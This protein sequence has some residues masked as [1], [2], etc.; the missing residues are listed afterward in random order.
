M[1]KIIDLLPDRNEYCL[2]IKS[3]FSTEFCNQIISDKKD[4]FKKAISHYPTSYRNNERQVIDTVEFSESL[5]NEIKNYI[6]DTITTSGISKKEKGTW[7]LAS[8]NSR[9]RICRYLSN[10]YFNK[11][12]DGIHYVDENTQSKLTFM[13]YLNGSKDFSGG[14]TLFFDAKNSSAPFKTYTPEKGDLIIFDHNLWHSGEIVSNGTKYVLRSD[15]IYTKD[16]FISHK[17]KLPFAEGHLGYIWNINKFNNRIITSGRDKK[18][19]IWDE[20]GNKITEINAHKN[21]ILKVISFDEKTFISASRDTSVNIYNETNNNQFKTQ[22]ITNYHKTTVLSLCKA[23]D[24]HFFSVDADGKVNLINIDGRLI[25]TKKAHNEWI[26]D[27]VMLNKSLFI[28][29][30]EDGS[31]KIWTYKAFKVIAEYK[32]NCPINAITI[33]NETIY[34]GTFKGDVLEF[35][36][37]KEKQILIKLNKY[38]IHTDLIRRLKVYNNFLL[39]ASE[40]NFLKIHNLGSFELIES[41]DHKNFVQDLE[42]INNTIITVSYEGEIHQFQMPTN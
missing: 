7:R 27:I 36:F 31:M 32:I 38:K 37:N 33:H 34:I 17:E 20:D 19:K 2:L 13:I 28:T 22:K 11:H 35:I 26:W 25:T 6:P 40:D 18:I 29:I 9:I 16:Q 23:D 3:A 15:I 41:F 21:S 4:S 14:K 1:K 8:L 24:E 12:L 39:S 10:Q 42:V 30:S 5:F